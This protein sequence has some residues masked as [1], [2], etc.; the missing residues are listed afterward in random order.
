MMMSAASGLAGM[1]LLALGVWL[2]VRAGAKP[3]QDIRTESHRSQA[4][5]NYNNR[6]AS[7]RERGYACLLAAG[8][9]LAMSLVMGL[10]N[11]VSAE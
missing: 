9:F 10:W 6:A 11:A 8:L 2:L 3:P 1:M 7:L 4:E 5:Y